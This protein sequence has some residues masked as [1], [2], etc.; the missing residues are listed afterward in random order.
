MKNISKPVPVKSIQFLFSPSFKYD[1]ELNLFW[2]YPN[3]H[4]M[5][6]E[7]LMSHF[8]N[9]RCRC[10]CDVCVSFLIGS[11]YQFTFE[12]NGLPPHESYTHT[13]WESCCYVLEVEHLFNATNKC[14][15]RSV[16][17]FANNKNNG[18]DKKRRNLFENWLRHS[19]LH[20]YCFFEIRLRVI[21]S[22]LQYFL[23]SSIVLISGW[24]F[25]SPL[26]YQRHS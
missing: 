8:T 20:Y 6:N 11:V 13:F 4:W 2:D 5:R 7:I 21:T 26:S 3:T 17:H 16:C 22:I 10:V 25:F 15:F 23:D 9:F 24:I 19:K 12:L 1:R 14:F 18:S